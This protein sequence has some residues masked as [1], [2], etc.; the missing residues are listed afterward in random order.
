MLK[1]SKKFG[2]EAGLYNKA[3]VVLKGL[4]MSMPEAI[5][6]YLEQVINKNSIQNQQSSTEN[7]FVDE[8]LEAYLEW[9]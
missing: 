2:V 4:G 8:A 7:L 5:T 3:D 1:E 9:F 6:E